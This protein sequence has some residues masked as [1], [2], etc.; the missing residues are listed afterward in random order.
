MRV[1]IDCDPGNGIPG[2]NI[3]DG[4]ALVIALLAPGIS[5]EL[6]TTVAGNTTVDVGYR[7]AHDLLQ[8]VQKSVPLQP[9]A[10]QPLLEPMEPWRR[11]LDHSVDCYHLRHLWQNVA[12][13]VPCAPAA[14]LAPY[15]IGELI[16]NYPGEITLVAIGPLTNVALALRLFPHMAQAVKRIVIMGGVFQVAGYLKDTNIAI[17]PEAAHIVLTSGAP[18]TLVPLDVTTQTQLTHTDLQRLEKLKNPF[19]CYLLHTLSPW[20]S[21]SMHTRQLPGCW[22]HDALTIA[23]LIEPELC[24]SYH[25]HIDVAL[26]GIARGIICR[27]GADNLKLRVGIPASHGT[28]AQ[29]LQSVDNQRLLALIFRLIEEAG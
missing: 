10:A 29:I 22:I 2:A 15:A 16:C 23:W 7:V 1:I 19:A 14:P 5:L 9:G 28:P 26:T 25:D 8:R 18:V 3:D 21:Y 27:Y 4:L 17:D 13:P 12:P 24:T 20:L 11:H 6:I